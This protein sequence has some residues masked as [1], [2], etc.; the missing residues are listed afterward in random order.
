MRKGDEDK[1]IRN[2]IVSLYI[3]I[4]LI[5]FVANRSALLHV[6]VLIAQRSVRWPTR[7]MLKIKK[8]LQIK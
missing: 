5:L 3:Y 7:D 2:V 1:K 4:L 8:L 6:C